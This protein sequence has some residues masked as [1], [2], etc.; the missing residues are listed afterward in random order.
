MKRKAYGQGHRSI[1]LK[2]ENRLSKKEKTADKYNES[3]FPRYLNIV[4]QTRN[5]RSFRLREI[6]LSRWPHLIAMKNK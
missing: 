2:K 5:E 6:F 3:L 4:P 1:Y